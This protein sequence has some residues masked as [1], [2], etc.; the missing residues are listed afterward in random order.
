MY[1]YQFAYFTIQTI[2][3]PKF[4][5]PLSSSG[6]VISPPLKCILYE[7]SVRNPELWYPKLS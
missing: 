4:R 7:C 2:R 6:E 3:K 1:F 5:I